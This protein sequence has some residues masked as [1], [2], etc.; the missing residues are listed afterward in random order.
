MARMKIKNDPQDMQLEF[1]LAN[2]RDGGPCLLGQEK[3][4]HRAGWWFERMRQIVERACD[5]EPAPLPR[6]V[7][8]FISSVFRQ[9]QIPAPVPVPEE[10]QVCE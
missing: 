6:P 5:W 1:T 8:T 7:Q 4:S 9:P 2:C 10:Q 3:R